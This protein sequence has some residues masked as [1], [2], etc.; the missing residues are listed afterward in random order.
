MN[1]PMNANPLAIPVTPEMFPRTSDLGLRAVWLI[2]L[3]SL[4]RR[5]V[6]SAMTGQPTSLSD[7]E[8]IEQLARLLGIGT[9]TF[10][11]SPEEAH[12]VGLL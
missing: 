5:A 4:E 9:A 2:E 12:M 10:G 1:N 3:R 11:L 8:R 6:Q 7:I